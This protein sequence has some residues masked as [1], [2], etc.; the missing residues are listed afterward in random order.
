MDVFKT[1]G[2]FD[3]YSIG[4]EARRQAASKG[5]LNHTFVQEASPKKDIKAKVEAAISK[6]EEVAGI[7][8]P[9]TE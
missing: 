4:V 9:D 7:A 6:A 8:A 1:K 3:P 2:A 5:M